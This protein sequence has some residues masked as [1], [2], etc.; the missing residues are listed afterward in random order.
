[1]EGL[2]KTKEFLS[3]WL[4]SLLFSQLELIYTFVLQDLWKDFSTAETAR[5][6]F[7]LCLSLLLSVNLEK[8]LGRRKFQYVTYLKKL[9]LWCYNTT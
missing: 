7:S 1:M 3:V 2:P 5:Q 4:S 9:L 8:S 6:V